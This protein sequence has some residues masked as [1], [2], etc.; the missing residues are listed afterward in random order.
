MKHIIEFELPDDQLELDFYI[1]CK[2][3]YSAI[4]DYVN[5]LRNE[6]KYNDKLDE[7]ERAV[8]EKARTEFYRILDNNNVHI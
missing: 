7:K 6:W 2:N 5:Y 8:I 4:A 3:Y 1:D